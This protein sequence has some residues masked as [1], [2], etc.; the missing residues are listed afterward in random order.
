MA[1]DS[2][3]GSTS[4]HRSETRAL[5]LAVVIYVLVFGLKIAAYAA[6]GVM[7]LLAEGLHTLSDIFVSGFLLLAARWS[8]KKPDQVHM[9]GY[10]RAQFVG[11]MGASILFISFTG[12]ELFREAIPRLFVRAPPTY[13]HLPL[14][15]A[16]LVGS[17][18]IAL[19]PLISLLRQKK[20]G[21]AAKAQL[22][23]LVNDQLGL[24][25]ALGGTVGVTLGFPLADPIA[26][27]AVATIICLNGIGLLRENLSYLVGRSPGPEALQKVELVAL[28]TAG[29]VAVHELRA[30][31]IGPDAVL[32]VLHINIARGTSIE[33]A[34]EIAKDVS[35][36][37]RTEAG[38]TDV[39]VHVDPVR[40]GAAVAA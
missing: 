25:A 32:A 37:L 1:D 4:D 23:E 5:Q 3:A 13:D 7:A 17:M 40:I 6:T 19:A 34:D 33:D 35:Q 31:Y 11:A 22:M 26:S 10:G 20:P 12:L 38:C 2:T 18:V 28:A 9:F 16:V 27:L 36:R 8:R 30:E 39:T 15:M 24:L 21:A 29:V 14:A